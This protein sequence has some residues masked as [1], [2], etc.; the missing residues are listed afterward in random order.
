MVQEPI[1]IPFHSVCEIFRRPL[2]IKER[3]VGQNNNNS[4]FHKA[5]LTV[6]RGSFF[7]ISFSYYFAL[8]SQIDLV[9]IDFFNK[10]KSN[11]KKS[12]KHWFYKAKHHEVQTIG[13]QISMVFCFHFLISGESLQCKFSIKSNCFHALLLSHHCFA[14][15]HAFSQWQ[16]ILR[17]I[18]R[19][20]PHIPDST[21]QRREPD[22]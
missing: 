15:L 6:C 18:T 7:R 21:S 11:L 10:Y 19:N 4:P 17:F 22:R 8:V 2:L 20:I 3:N 14:F 1:H 5:A 12:F 9:K 13:V 16:R